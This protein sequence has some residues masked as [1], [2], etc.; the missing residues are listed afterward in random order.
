MTD[1]TYDTG[2]TKNL[3]CLLAILFLKP[4]TMTRINKYKISFLL[5][6]DILVLKN[7]VL[8]YR[9][10]DA[11]GYTPASLLVM[12]KCCSPSSYR[13]QHLYWVELDFPI[14]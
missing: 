2:V 12:S 11:P 10:W 3:F 5:L 8:N 4:Q 7:L 1:D 9:I 6:Y 14:V 13:L